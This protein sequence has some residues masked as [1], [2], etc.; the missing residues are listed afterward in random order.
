MWAIIGYFK[1]KINRLLMIDNSYDLKL[2]LRRDKRGSWNTNI[3]FNRLEELEHTIRKLT[4]D[5]ENMDRID[6]ISCEIDISYELFIKCDIDYGGDIK[7]IEKYI[8]Y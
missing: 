6:S 1:Y 7:T 4:H 3:K 2:E 8:R 5:R